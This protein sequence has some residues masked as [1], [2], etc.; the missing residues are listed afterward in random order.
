MLFEFIR[1]LTIPFNQIETYIPKKGR[2]LDVG[3]GHGVFSR[4]VAQKYP[5]LEV[6][7]IDPSDHKI[8]IAKSKS[9]YL[10]NL[11][12]KNLYLKDVHESFDCITIMD[13]LYLLPNSKKIEILSLSKKLLQKNGLLILNEIDTS[14]GL[15]FKFLFL[16]EII[17]VKLLKYTFS[18]NKKL[19]FLNSKG[20]TRELKNL[21]F[22]TTAKKIKGFLPFYH[23]MY[24]AKK[25]N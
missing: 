10:P 8:D 12:Y 20:Y 22:K 17:M 24:L 9:P 18:D 23:I 25:M 7:G 16:E 6:L 4:M 11:S 1:K 15:I 3:C 14:Q 5:D 2:I 19:F 21:G 13:V